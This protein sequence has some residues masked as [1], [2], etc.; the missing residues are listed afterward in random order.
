MIWSYIV[1]NVLQEIK[2]NWNTGRVCLIIYVL[3]SFRIQDFYR[4]MLYIWQLTKRKIYVLQAMMM[5][6]QSRAISRRM[7]ASV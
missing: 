5:I 7:A 1:I 3:M 6:L 4:Q 2:R